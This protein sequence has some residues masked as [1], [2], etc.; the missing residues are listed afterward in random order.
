MAWIVVIKSTLNVY[1]MK[2]LGIHLVSFGSSLTRLIEIN[3]TPK[4]CFFL[5]NSG[6]ISSKYFE[7]ASN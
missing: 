3:L 7:P 1:F 5:F 4:K 2:F 6:K